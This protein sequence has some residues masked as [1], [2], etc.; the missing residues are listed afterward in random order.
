MC[1]SVCPG[2][3]YANNTDSSCHI[4]PVELKCNNCT[5]VNSSNLVKCTSCI[6]GFYFQAST[7]TCSISCN[8][9]Q[10]ANKGN[11]YCVSCDSSCLTC[12]GPGASF[13][14]S[15][16][17]SLFFV[18]NITGGYCIG[19]CLPVGY[20]QSGTSCLA[21]DT[22]CYTC[23]GTSSS[24]CSSCPDS[25]YLSGGYCRYV[26]PA[27]TYPNDTLLTC[28]ACSNNCTYCFG[29]TN[30]NCTGCISGLVLFNF[31]CSS[32][33]PTGY[34]INQWNVCFSDFINMLTGCVI[35]VMLLLMWCFRL[36]Y[37][38]S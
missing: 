21:C 19:G 8:S 38:L 17:S 36:L 37:F 7:S 5:Y 1:W 22:T 6:Y 24:D 2:G 16:N 23:N 30:D 35:M 25:T 31:T 13:C 26:C 28:V 14:T 3:Y 12:G 20:T 27:A 18:A 32:A 34:T 11:N 15:C 9:S 33:C 10:Y 4:C 29:G